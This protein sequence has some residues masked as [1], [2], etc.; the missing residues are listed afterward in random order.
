MIVELQNI[1]KTYESTNSHVT[2][3]VLKGISLNITK[4]QSISIVGPSG[5]G[6][7]TLLNIIGTLD[8]PS[9]GIYKFKGEEIHNF[10]QNQLSEIRNQKI[11]FIFQS[12]HLLPQLNIIEN[13]LIPTIP[14]KDRN[15]K[16][17]AYNRALMLL[18][19]VDLTSHKNKLPSQLSGGEC[20]RVA[21]IRSLINNPEIILADEPTGSLDEDSA[22]DIGELLVELNRENDIALVVVTHSVKLASKIG[23]IYNLTGGILSLK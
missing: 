13:V 12:H 5:C 7:S 1:T 3:N 20:Q 4:G 10:T 2:N 11:G 19:R 14:I 21:V 17:D 6:K 8:L 23:I 15:Y 9:S 22:D 18:D 16:K